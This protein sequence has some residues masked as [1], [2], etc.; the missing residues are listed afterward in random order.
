ML[1]SPD[2]FSFGSERKVPEEGLEHPAENPVIIARSDSGGAKSGAPAASFTVQ[3]PH[4]HRVIDA[5]PRLLE[6]F[7][8][9]ILGIVEAAADQA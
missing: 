8:G 3:D 9:R 2:R 1:C 4:L 6:L 7:R 5:W